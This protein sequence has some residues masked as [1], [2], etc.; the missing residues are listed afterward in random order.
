V[1]DLAGPWDIQFDPAKR[2]PA[3]AVRFDKLV[4]WSAR[5][6]PAIQYYSG[7]AVYRTTF[8]LPTGE[9]STGG[10][11]RWWI[12]LGAVKNVAAVKLN[13]KEL[14]VSWTEPFR[15]EMTGHVL[16]KGNELAV[17]V[18]NLWPNRLIGDRHLPRDERQ[19]R[20]NI[21][22]FTEDSPLLESGLLGPVRLMR[23][24]K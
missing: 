20:T 17:E 16:P 5:P 2:G 11:Q 22:K 23:A 10:E 14:G 21:R 12:D 9:Q 13:G 4:S 6:E 24:E 3:E 8:D 7:A 1:Q 19:T 18:T 15:V